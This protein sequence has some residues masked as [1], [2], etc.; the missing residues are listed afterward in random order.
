MAAAELEQAV[1][2]YASIDVAGER[3]RI[4]FEEAGSG[5]VL[6]CLHT[7][8]AD[9][10]QFRYLLNDSEIT[11]AWRVVAF[12]LPFHGRSQP[13]GTWW[14]SP[15]RLQAAHYERIVLAV[16]EGLGLGRPVIMG[17]SMGGQIVLR[18]A[19]HHADRIAGAIG[20]E[21]AAYVTGR[22]NEYLENPGIDRCE[23]AAGYTLGLCAPQS[24]EIYRRENA[25]YY[26]QGAPGVYA[27]DL[28]FYGE[29]WDARAELARVDTRACP[30]ALLTGE[31]DYSCLPEATREAG[32][33][34]PGAQVTIMPEI[35]HF[36]MIEHY[37]RFR[38]YVSPVLRDMRPHAAARYGVE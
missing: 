5:P 34:I 12:D 8:G 32:A 13:L 4:Y 25:W 19:A 38:E 27:G 28:A 3:A 6:L 14:E 22:I 17:C 21:S 18:L 15:Y 29:P 11:R 35:G 26:A 23:L 24:P 16:I 1:G 10:R 33:L 7:A 36:P 20:I 37:Q 9:S 31:Y 2:R 30:V